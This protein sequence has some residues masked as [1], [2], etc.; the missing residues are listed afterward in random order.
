MSAWVKNK[1][2]EGRIRDNVEQAGG[3]LILIVANEHGKSFSPSGKPS[4]WKCGAFEPCPLINME[5]LNKPLTKRI[6][7]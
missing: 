7:R 2:G 5:T 3:W 4:G 1:E 6:R